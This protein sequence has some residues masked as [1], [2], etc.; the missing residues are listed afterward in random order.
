MKSDTNIYLH[1]LY[2]PMYTHI[3]YK[4][5]IQISIG[6]VFS[7]MESLSFWL[8]MNLKEMLTFLLWS[9]S[10]VWCLS[11]QVIAESCV[12]RG[13]LLPRAAFVTDSFLLVGVPILHMIPTPFPYVWHRETDNE[14]CLHYPTI[15]NL[16][17]IMRIFVSEYLHLQM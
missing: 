11:W 12:C 1:T 4:L 13:D 5:L 10:A 6:V 15:N 3:Q 14:S 9:G 2:I 7:L 16:N 17:K 8:L